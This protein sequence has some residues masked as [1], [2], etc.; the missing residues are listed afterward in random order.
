MYLRGFGEINIIIP[1]TEAYITTLFKEIFL[2][3]LF[4]YWLYFH[5]VSEADGLNISIPRKLLVFYLLAIP[6]LIFASPQ[7]FLLLIRPYIEMFILIGI[8]LLSYDLSR[9]EVNKLLLS[10]L[11]SGTVIGCF[12]FYHYFVDPTFLIEGLANKNV[13]YGDEPITAFMGPRLQSIAGNPNILGT[14]A[15][16]I[17]IVSMN[18][19]SSKYINL[20]QRI[21]AGFVLLIMSTT[22]F[23]T[24]GRDEIVFLFVAILLFA[25][26]L[27]NRK[28]VLSIIS[29]SVLGLI[30]NWTSIINTFSVLIEYGNP[31][32]KIWYTAWEFYSFRLLTGGLTEANFVYGALDSTYLRLLMHTG[33]LGVMLFLILNIK[34]IISLIHHGYQN[35]DTQ[36]ITI[37]IAIICLL[38]IFAT[39][40]MF[41]IYP[42]NSFYWALISI[43]AVISGR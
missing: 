3:I 8:P 15:M 21:F 13:Y 10:F 25:V 36:A 5:S 4:F 6:I 19:V 23:L 27:K 28:S 37:A 20:K 30:L 11:V 24:R 2:I 31:R 42:I 14:V 38:G 40:T 16:I 7:R 35:Q 1:A 39:T 43:G 29:G 41:Y 26:L 33:I 18:F 22:L 12:A 34:I 17:S 32:V 9:R